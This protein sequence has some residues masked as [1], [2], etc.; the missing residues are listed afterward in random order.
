MTMTTHSTG[1]TLLDAALAYVDDGVNVAIIP[2]TPTADD[3]TSMFAV[4]QDPAQ[5]T[6]LY[7]AT[8]SDDIGPRGA[9]AMHLIFRA[10]KAAVKLGMRPA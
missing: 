10:R 4:V 3:D 7:N 5:H 1:S 8:Y 2:I 9:A 6:V